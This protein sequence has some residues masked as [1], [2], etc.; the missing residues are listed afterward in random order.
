MADERLDTSQALGQGKNFEA[1]YHTRDIVVV[2]FELERDHASK[3]THLSFRQ[4]VVGMR[5]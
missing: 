2:P 1:T 3:A 5:G 4:F